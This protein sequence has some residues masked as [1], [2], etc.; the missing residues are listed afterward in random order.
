LQGA[1]VALHLSV[2]PRTERLDEHVFGAQSG[3]GGGDV[4]GASV[5]EVV[6]GDDSFEW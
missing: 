6:V 3:D 5:A 2:L 1:V 4:V